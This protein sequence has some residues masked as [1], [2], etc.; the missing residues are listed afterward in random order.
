MGLMKKAARRATPR[1][2]RKA[3]SVIKHPVGTAARAATPRSV[4][5]AKR[6]AFNVTHPLNTAENAL[7]NAGSPPRRSRRSKPTSPP[8]KAAGA[9]LKTQDASIVKPSRYTTHPS[10]AG[11]FRIARPTDK[12]VYVVLVAAGDRPHELADLMI[13]INKGNTDLPVRGASRLWR[14]QVRKQ[15]E[16]LPRFLAVVAPDVGDKFAA[17]LAEVGASVELWVDD[18]DINERVLPLRS[19]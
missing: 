13:R 1:S 5:K 12:E 3:K 15:F 19:T 6:T 11:A 16:A 9:A 7:L 2:V 18:D 10:C 17:A 14:W 8:G 4:R